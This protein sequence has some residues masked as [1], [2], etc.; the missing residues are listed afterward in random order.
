MKEVLV[1]RGNANWNHNVILQ[2]I[3]LL[4]GKRQMWSN[5]NSYTLLMSLN[6]YSYFWKQFG[7][8]YNRKIYIIWPRNSTLVMHPTEVHTPKDFYKNLH[9]SP[10]YNGLTLGTIQMF[11]WKEW[12]N[13]LWYIHKMEYYK[14]MRVNELQLYVTHGWRLQYNIGQKEPD[15]K[16]RYYMILFSRLKTA[17]FILIYASEIRGV[18]TPVMWE[19]WR[20]QKQLPE[21]LDIMY[22]LIWVLITQVFTQVIF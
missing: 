12:I 7:S 13:K 19:V 22:F 1:A 18:A 14:I 21:I 9:N 4:K 3:Y 15:T 10:I 2:L 17:Q 11:I 6:L 20:R 16:N 8:I 5:W